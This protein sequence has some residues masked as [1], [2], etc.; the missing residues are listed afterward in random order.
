ME[1]TFK[2]SLV[3]KCVD[4]CSALSIDK[5][6]D[7]DDY[8]IT[9]YRSFQKTSL[10]DKFKAIYNIIFG[11]EV[12]GS[13]VVLSKQEFELIKNFDNDIQNS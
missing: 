3:I 5:F 12:V 9:T 10:Q 7:D 6:H 2:K 1:D 11:G 8:F 4:N 13:E